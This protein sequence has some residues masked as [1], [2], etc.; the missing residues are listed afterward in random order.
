MSP[1]RVDMGVDYQG[2]GSIYALGPGVITEADNAWSGAEGAP[3]PGAF[4]V[5]QL[6]SG[7]LAGKYVY[8]AEDVNTAVYKGE[9]VT[10]QTVIGSFT[11]AGQIETG[12]AVGPSAPGETMAAQA[13]QQATGADPGAHPTAFGAAYNNLLQAVGATPGII[14]G[15]P[16]G[17][18]PAGWPYANGTATADLTSSQGSGFSLLNP[19]SWVGLSGASFR[20]D[21]QRLGL[22]V[23]GGVLVL[24]GIWL[25]AGN[26]TMSIALDAVAPEVKAAKKVRHAS[27]S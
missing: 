27:H 11:G 4:I 17:T 16:V 1:E 20:D 19:L 12:Y 9:H 24:V 25:L 7:P 18:L 26:K 10:S 5:E 3:Y 8:L 21:L 23:F 14:S 15:T 6:T 13:N 22:I 2:T